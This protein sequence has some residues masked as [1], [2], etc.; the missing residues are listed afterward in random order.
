VNAE[1]RS[2]F[3]FSSEKSGAIVGRE[4]FCCGCPRDCQDHLVECGGF[5]LLHTE[6]GD[7]SFALIIFERFQW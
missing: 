3:E 2:W 4:K 7:M 6:G 5:A 1:D